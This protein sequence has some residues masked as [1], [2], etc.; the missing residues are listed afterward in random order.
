MAVVRFQPSDEND[1]VRETTALLQAGFDVDVICVARPNERR[2]E[3]RSFP[4][5]GP[6]SS[7]LTIRRLRIGKSRGSIASYLWQYTAWLVGVTW[8]L[9]RHGLVRPYHAV[10]ITTLPD[11]QVLAALPARIRGTRLVVFFK[12]PAEQLFDTLFGGTVSRL[13]ALTTRLACRTADHCLCVTEAHRQQLIASGAPATRIEVIGNATAPDRWPDVPAEAIPPDHF[14]AVCHG[15]IEERWGHEVIL[16]AAARV[17]RETDRLRVVFTG[18]GGFSPRVGE[19]I[20]EL[21]LDDA[22]E[23]RGWVSEPDL[24]ALLRRADVGLVAQL[25][26]PYSNLVHTGKMYDFFQLGV[27]VIASDLAATRSD[28]DGCCRFYRADAPEDLAAALLDF[29]A[30]PESAAAYADA[31]TARLDTMGWQALEERYVR[32]VAGS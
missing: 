25:P 19:L 31:A 1:L 10:Q 30:D 23:N 26:S 27:P 8:L 29:I 12:E 15:T 3:V 9:M 17:G 21:E 7:T 5:P 6:E 16:R 22:V 2:T 4:G 20:R 24:S 11:H 28:F 18:T 32:A 13:V 14:V